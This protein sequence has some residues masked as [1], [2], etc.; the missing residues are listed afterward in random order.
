MAAGPSHTAWQF[1]RRQLLSALGR[2]QHPSLLAGPLST[3][4][5]CSD[6]DGRAVANMLT[7]PAM[8]GFGD[9]SQWESGS[10]QSQG[11][12]SFG[13]DSGLAL[14]LCLHLKE[15]GGLSRGQGT[16]VH[17]MYGAALQSG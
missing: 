14:Y 9:L 3:A 1:Y 5:L 6:K 4:Q 11:K 10:V 2:G 16:Y 15:A 7:A 17:E 13:W 8:L 12:R